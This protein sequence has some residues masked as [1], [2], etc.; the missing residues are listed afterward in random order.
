MSDPRN[1]NKVVIDGNVLIDLTSDTVEASKLLTGYTAHAKSGALI[2]GTCTFNADTKDATAAASDILNG[3]TAYGSNGS[4]ITGSMPNRGSAT[5]TISTKTG[6]YTIP[7][8]YHDGGGKVSI[9][10]TEQNKL[11]PTNIRKGI[12]VLGVTGTLSDQDDLVIGTKIVAAG[13]EDQTVTPP[14]GTNYLASVTVKG[15]VV[16]M[17]ENAAGGITYTLEKWSGE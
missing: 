14:E 8:G 7:S 9:A 15:L 13:F 3:V 6:T 11:I 2:T 12:T 4:K 10:T 1:F 17:T 5:G 16:T